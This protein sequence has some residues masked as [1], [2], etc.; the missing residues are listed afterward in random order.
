MVT[1][2]RPYVV[3]CLLWGFLGVTQAQSSNPP[4]GIFD[5]QDVLTL[6]LSG[7]VRQLV[8]DRGDDSKYQPFTLSFQTEDSTLVSLPIEIKTRGHFRKSMA[9]CTYPPLLLHFKNQTTGHRSIFSQQNKLK[10][11]TPC[12]GEKY[13]VRE[14]VVYK[15]YSLITP[16][17]FRARLV[18]VIYNDSVTN[19]KS[20]PLFGILLEEEDQMAARNNAMIIKGK[21]LRPEQTVEEDFLQMAVFEYLIGNTDWS[22]QYYQN[23]KLIAG[24][25]LQ[26][27]SPV[28]YD[29]DHA[30]IVGAPYAHPAEE[31]LL[32]S[33]TER[34]YRGYCMSSI[35]SFAPTVTHF[36]QL[37]KEIY[38]V[39]TNN[40]L[41]E[42]SYVKSTTRFL[43]EFFE[44]IN[45]PK[46][47]KSEFG[48]PCNK[49]GTGNVVIQ[50]LKKN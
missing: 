10:L 20:K 23:I 21:K 45:N 18:K 38:E 5:R 16:K 25:S 40:P 36:N 48:Y 13:V 43:D 6:E 42:S 4:T 1:V 29:F 11:V 47:L 50:G 9:N 44:T 46:S 3:A 37:K 2:Y 14:Y 41:L 27:P 35:A 15:L 32:N 8:K 24:D 34:R 28:P 17:S 7:N 39:Y 33:T 49:D 30:G 19:K 26:A 22:V 12:A 31:L